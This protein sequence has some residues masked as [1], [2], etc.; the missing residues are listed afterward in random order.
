MTDKVVSLV[1]VSTTIDQP[2]IDLLE[3]LLDEAKAGLICG[4]AYAI[5][6]PDGN[7]TNGWE[8]INGTLFPMGYA[9]S[10]LQHRYFAACLEK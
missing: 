4:V 7:V 9:I 10:I 5:V 6:R 8:G 3:R 2:T 1:Q